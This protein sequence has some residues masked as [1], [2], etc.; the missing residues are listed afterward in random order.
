MTAACFA[1]IESDRIVPVLISLILRLPDWDKIFRPCIPIIYR[2]RAHREKDA[3][4]LCDL[5]KILIVKILERS[6]LCSNVTTL[7]IKFAELFR[8]DTPTFCSTLITS[9][10]AA[11]VI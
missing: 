11:Y 9:T 6:S 7:Q 2:D 8:K 4:L 1:E 10:V 5:Q 3:V